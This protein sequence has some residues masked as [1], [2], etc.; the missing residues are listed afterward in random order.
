ML[1]SPC[2]IRGQEDG[3]NEKP[4][5][6]GRELFTRNDTAAAGFFATGVKLL[7]S[8]ELFAGVREV[9]I[10]HDGEHY[11]L[12]PTRKGKLILTK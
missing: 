9:V 10:E 12:R 11:R 1:K 8:R 7:R 6:G 5:E 4:K 2:S 3:M